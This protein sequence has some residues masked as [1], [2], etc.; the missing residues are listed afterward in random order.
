MHSKIVIAACPYLATA[1]ATPSSSTHQVLSFAS[2]K[3]NKELKKGDG[4]KRQRLTGA[5]G[6]RRLLPL[7]LQPPSVL[8]WNPPA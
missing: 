1:P 7:D 5:A 3:A 2:F 4:A 6:R 8:C